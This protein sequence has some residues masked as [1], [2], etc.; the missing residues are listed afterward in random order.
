MFTEV[1]VAGIVTTVLIE[2]IHKNRGQQD[3]AIG[4]TFSSLFAIGVIIISFGQ[5]DAAPR[6]RVRV[7]R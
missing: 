5:T 7:V 1:L 6:R 4:I 3:A 2:L